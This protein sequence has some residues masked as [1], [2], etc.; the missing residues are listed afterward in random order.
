MSSPQFVHLHTHSQYSLLDGVSHFGP[1]FDRVGKLGMNTVALTDHGNMFGALAFLNASKKTDI[2]PIIGCEVYLSPTTYTDRQSVEA[3]RKR[4]HLVLLAK[5][6]EGY[7]NLSWLVSK[8]Y[9]EGFYHRPRIDKELL[10][11]R[12]KGLI[13]LSG[14]LSGVISDYFNIGREKDAY[15]AADDFAQIMGPDNFYVE[16]MDHG[17]AD[18]KRVNQQLLEVAKKTGLPLVATNDSHY[19]GPRDA[20]T[21]EL[22]ICVATGK[23]LDDQSR[24]RFDSE[25]F[26]LKSPEEMYKVF[27]HLPGALQ[28]TVE[29]AARCGE[30]DFRD[31]VL[32]RQDDLMPEYIP[33]DGSTPEAYLRRLVDT[34]LVKRYGTITDAYRARTDFELDVI[35][36][37]GFISY[38]LVVW[39]FINYAVE[40]G[41]SV[42]PGRGSGAGSIVAYALGITDLCPL[43]NK[44][45]FERFLNPERVSMPDFD[46]DFCP[47]RREEVIQYVRDKYG[48]G[49][50]SNIITFGKMKAKA[51]VR[52]VGRVM[53]IPLSTV[54]RVAKMIPDGPKV[55]L[56]KAL[57]ESA[58]FKDLYDSDPQIKDMVDRAK[59]IEG[60]V[61]QP[62]MHAAG[63]IVCR[64]P[65]I[66]VI[67]LY[68]QAGKGDAI[69]QFDM[70]ECES[71]GLLKVDFLGLKNLTII[72]D[73]I[74]IVKDKRGNDVNWEDIGLTD[75]DTYKLFQRG[76]GFGVFQ[77]E[78]SGMREMLR[79]AKPT[80]FEDIVALIALYRPGPLEY[81]PSFCRRKHGEEPITY[82]HPWLEESLKET[83]GVMVYQEQVMQIAQKLAGYSLGGAD[84]LRRAMGKK[85]KEEMD[86]QR[87]IFTE[88][89]AKNDISAQIANQV[90]DDIAKF[91][92]YAFNKA[93]AAAYAVITYR[94]G[95]L[96]AHYQPEFMAALLTNEIRSGTSDKLGTYIGVAR[97]M[98]LRVLQPDINESEGLFSVSDG[99]VR[100]GLAAIKNVGHGPVAH[101]TEARTAGPF[102]SFQDF[103]D[104]IDSSKINTRTIECLITA[105]AFDA[106]EGTR[107]QLLAI[108]PDSLEIGA[109][110]RN[111]KESGQT[112][113]FDML[114]EGDDGADMDSIALP[115][116]PDWTDREKFNKEKEL[117][118]MFLSG[119]PLD[120]FRPDMESFT[121]HT[122]STL[123]DLEPNLKVAM[124]GMITTS[125]EITTKNNDPMAFVELEDFEGRFEIVVFPRVFEKIRHLLV[126]DTMLYIEGRFSKRNA[127][128]DG[129]VLV[130]IAER[131][132]DLRRSRTRFIDIDL[133]ASSLENGHLEALRSLLRKHK[134]SVAVRLGLMGEG[135]EQIFVKTAARFKANPT[136]AFLKEFNAL[137]FPKKLKFSVK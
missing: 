119:H 54:D 49:N 21:Q 57:D 10:A 121:S 12:S 92:S 29:I 60:A 131:L 122:S 75:E 44:L 68:K 9:L 22:L 128:S 26:F 1:L 32:R 52:D 8:G 114:G 47:L 28:N 102:T 130:D 82:A 62:G 111:L 98:G 55:T 69:S 56:K 90:F 7:Q 136:D 58:D 112:S 108:L 53:G 91:A 23:T 13:A 18:Q 15:Q 104:R 107:P 85:K 95:Y 71:I 42:G 113:L 16:L 80:C 93:H 46:I 43:K 84:I 72:E 133:N 38:F 127:D 137:D 14:C 116:I 51:A 100:F 118:G 50:V 101:I 87:S 4:Q 77:V 24:M 64:K 125:R 25:E 79:M 19:L 109:N 103:C 105:G 61:R 99:D 45:F 63:V 117:A 74:R 37:M 40:Q 76:D 70:N 48:A 89:C 126:T 123:A 27:G 120:R 96:K 135:G 83:Y 59:R 65:L 97:D 67:P 33:P 132:E 88:G 73:C 36:G 66:D 20:K 31:K 129:N 6:Y 106:M 115:N 3:R 124:V 81:I 78:S 39:D 110:K 41:I 2:K 134:G 11:Q 35:I 94:T 86:K 34:G 17:M 5:D 30:G